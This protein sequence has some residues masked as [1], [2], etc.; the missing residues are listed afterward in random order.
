MSGARN[1]NSAVGSLFLLFSF[2]V[3]DGNLLRS[4]VLAF[5][6]LASFTRSGM[7]YAIN[8]IAGGA[9]IAAGNVA[10]LAVTVVSTLTFSHLARVNSFKLVETTKRRMRTRLS[11]RLLD[12]RADYLAGRDQGKVYSIVTHE[13]NQISSA[14]TNF[15]ES[16]EACLLI[17]FCIPYLFYLSWPSG[18]ATLAAVVIGGLGYLLAQGPAQASAEAASRIE[19]QFFDRI[20]D[21]LRGYKELRL[22]EAR[23][24]DL[25]DE[26]VAISLR[27]R[28]LKLVA[29]RYYSLGQV[30]AQG[31]MMGLLCAIVV[32]LPLLAGTETATVLQILTV[33][34]LTYGPIETVMGNL[35]S[36]S[37]ATVAKRLI[38]GLERD[39]IKE[40]ED[41]AAVLVDRSLPPPAFRAIELKGATTILTSTSAAGDDESFT[42][43]PLDLTLVP[44]EVVFICGGNG[45]GKSTLISLLTGLRQPDAG[46]ILLNGQAVGTA[47]LIRYRSLF[48]AVFSEFHL[49]SRLYGLSDDER[50]AI[51]GHLAELDLAHRV[52]VTDEKFSTLALSTGQKRRL[53]LSVALAEKRP[54]IVL[55]EFAAD[56]DPV[57]RALFYDVLV[58]Q[59]ARDG[60]LVLAV[61]H[62]EHRF[63]QC[64]R[65]I[66][67]EAGQI[68]SDERMNGG[69][70]K[71]I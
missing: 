40:T 56:Q 3:R 34:L 13:V 18:A 12:A 64:D 25:Q 43:G 70:R 1:K 19:W 27:E 26:I 46:E 69:A 24:E 39:L 36:F 68:I 38:D 15:I 23:K 17:A 57:R 2:L 4:P 67:M 6:I 29:E 35:S 50:A 44:G 37:R 42:V 31:A 45:A 49:F 41:T 9:A 62:D 28:A 47:N 58:P 5:A 21:V 71:A 30:F 33:V 59:M 54:I 61:T 7:I 11:R 65:L 66:R 51:P 16:L 22:R 63:T 60:H 48:S 52:S 10:L 14:S 20:N 32:G 53:A 8:L 55:D